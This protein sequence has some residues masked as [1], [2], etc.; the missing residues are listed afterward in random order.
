MNA[1]EYLTYDEYGHPVT[2]PR[3]RLLPLRR[4]ASWWTPLKWTWARHHE[5]LTAVAIIAA[6]VLY[7]GF[8][9]VR[10]HLAG[11]L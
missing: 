9:I 1:P 6:F 5:T 11:R 8:Q 4:R 10:A 2:R 7:L 3:L